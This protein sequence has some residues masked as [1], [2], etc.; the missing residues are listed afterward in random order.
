M[1]ERH[2][3]E[4][5]DE[6][7]QTILW[8][9]RDSQEPMCVDELFAEVKLDDKAKIRYRMQKLT[10]AGLVTVARTEKNHNIAPTNYYTPTEEGLD[11]LFQH[12][13]SVEHAVGRKQYVESLKR[14]RDD[15]SEYLSEDEQDKSRIHS[16][17][18]K[19]DET[20]QKEAERIDDLK[21][22]L[23][24]AQGRIN[25][26]SEDKS[27]LQED[28]HKIKQEL[29]SIDSSISTVEADIR[30][31]R[32]TQSDLIE[33]YQDHQ[34]QLDDL[35]RWIESLDSE[36]DNQSFSDLLFD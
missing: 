25:G 28:V 34:N 31:L 19:L 12:Q 26:I 23:D 33:A 20:L 9:L 17:I 14:L 29:E 13:D 16:K 8:V 6:N 30:E 3:G 11:W 1:K 22:S 27:D 35:Y 10:D 24:W 32:E 21:I 15:F 2:N 36:L 18:N 7:A 4:I 5:I